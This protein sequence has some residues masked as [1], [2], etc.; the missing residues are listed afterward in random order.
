[1]H[2]EHTAL[3]LHNRYMFIFVSWMLSDKK[4][5]Y[6]WLMFFSKCKSHI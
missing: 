6:N 4:S 3:K 2:F 1:M 5:F